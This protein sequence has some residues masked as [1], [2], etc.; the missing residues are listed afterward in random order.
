MPWRWPFSIWRQPKTMACTEYWLYLPRPKMPPQAAYMNRMLHFPKGPDGERPIGSTEALLFSDIRLHIALVL[1]ERNVHV[2][3]PDLFEAHVEPTP[4]ILAALSESPAL[5]KLQYLSFDRLRDDR[6]LQFMPYLLLAVAD[7]TKATAA[8]DTVS[9]RLFL[10]ETLRQE[11]ADQP[12]ARRPD[13]HVR[14]VWIQTDLGG[15]GVTRGLLKVGLPELETPESASDHQVVILE[16]LQRTVE[17]LW[18]DR[19]YPEF[20]AVRCFDDDFE[21]HLAYR[22]K[23]PALAKILRVHHDAPRTFAS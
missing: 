7:L 1:R 17:K 18:L 6:H 15:K 12:D 10:V 8:F 23:G 21:V 14:T 19:T 4:E 16:V 9:E 5:A 20:V 11:L 22:R 2:F 13:F 3:R